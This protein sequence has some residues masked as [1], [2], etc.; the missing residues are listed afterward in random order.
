MSVPPKRKTRQ[1]AAIADVLEQAQLPL[2]AR[3]ILQRARKQVP[4]LSQATVY[5]VLNRLQQE[6]RAALL[7]LPGQTPLYES[8]DRRHHH[9][10]RCLSCGQLFEV[11]G[12][13]ELL[14]QLV[15][16]GFQLQQHEVFLAGTCSRCTQEK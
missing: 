15:P 6:D 13:D 8:T 11:D 9:F 10:F 3:Q 2:T 12:C 5:R 14:R 16:E 7:E 4:S 1:Q